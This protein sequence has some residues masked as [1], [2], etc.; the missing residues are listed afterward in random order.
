M[1]N[2]IIIG[3]VVL[4]VGGFIALFAFAPQQN[5]QPLDTSEL[6]T[7]IPEDQWPEGVSF[8]DLPEN[9][10]ARNTCVNHGGISMHIHPKLTIIVEDQVASIPANVGV[11]EECMKAIHTHDTTGT[12]H[13]E[14][15]TPFDFTLGD[16]FAN[17]GYGF[18][19]NTI[20]GQEVDLAHELV[21]TV[22]GEP[23]DEFE[24]LVLRDLDDIVIRYQKVDGGEE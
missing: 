6:S 8:E 19:S 18:N 7:D 20:L 3:A 9:L 24:N 11:T 5:S 13:V 2:G 1:K 15:L 14:F 16:F 22:N 4:V 17:W 23:S 12:L 21:M 10:V